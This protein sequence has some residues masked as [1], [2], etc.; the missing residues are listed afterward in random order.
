M[1][2]Q[3]RLSRAG[4]VFWAVLAVTAAAF[5]VLDGAV[6]LRIVKLN[7]KLIVLGDLGRQAERVPYAEEQL[8]LA[9]STLGDANR[10]TRIA[11]DMLA[12]V[13]EERGRLDDAL[14]LRQQEIDVIS[15]SLGP[16]H[17]TIALT[18]PQIA[19]LLYGLGRRSEAEAH[20]K[21]ALE[22]TEQ[23]EGPQ[24]ERY[25]SALE[26]VGL[27]LM[28]NGRE[29]DG[30]RL[31]ERG[32]QIQ[33]AFGK[34]DA[35]EPTDSVNRGFR[36]LSA[37]RLDDA[38]HELR[39]AIAAQ[40]R[41]YGPDHPDLVPALNGLVLV[42]GQQEKYEQ[43]E[44]IAVR[45]LAIAERAYGKDHLS[46]ASALASLA[47]VKE[48]LGAHLIGRADTAA[49]IEQLRVEVLTIHQRQLAIAE[50]QLPRNHPG[51]GEA[52]VGLGGSL[53]NAGR[54]AEAYAMLERGIEIGA[55]A[56]Q[57]PDVDFE[58]GAKDFDPLAAAYWRLMDI[59]AGMVAGRPETADETFRL[60]QSALR[61]ST[62][63]ALAQMS[64]RA[65]AG[66]PELAELVRR[67]Q[68]L[69]TEQK[70]HNS[71]IYA[72]VSLAADARDRSNETALQKALAE[73]TD[74]IAD[75]DQRL[76]TGFPRFSDLSM[77]RTIGV[78]EMQA[79]LRD[80]EVL[81]QYYVPPLPYY[82]WAKGTVWAIS[83]RAVRLV[84][85]PVTA[86]EIDD[87][88][89]AL[90]CGLDEA[91]WLTDAGRT[92][93]ANLLGLQPEDIAEAAKPPLRFSAER[94][95]ALYAALFSG[96]EDMTRGQQL[97][98]VP[99][100]PLSALPLQVL[101]TSQP[102]PGAALRDMPWLGT[103]QPITILPSAG[104]LGALRTREP[105]LMRA[106]KPYIG[107]GNPLLRGGEGD[108]AQAELARERSTCQRPGEVRIAQAT[109]AHAP[110]RPV[111]RNGLAS[112][113][114]LD[115]LGPLPETADE[116]CD[117]AAG[118][119]AEDGS[120]LLGKAASERALKKLN[121]DGVLARYRILHFATHGALSGEI[122]GSAEP[123]LVLTPPQAASRD[124]DG[125]LT[126]SEITE[127]DIAADW[128]ILSACNTAGGANQDLTSLSGL[129]RAFFYAGARALL[130]SHW[131]VNSQASVLLATRAFGALA[132]DPS[133]GRAEAMRA[134]MA[135]LATSDQPYQNHPSYW[136][137]FVLV[138]EGG[139]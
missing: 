83:R 17:R 100:G 4:V 122:E 37:G 69:V 74:R 94:A 88:V 55:A 57:T 87:Q 137:P 102:S 22:L 138:G 96:I 56:A 26:H 72:A 120:V 89:A 136:A 92:R 76:A 51:V 35:Q 60:A 80:D 118:L 107:F 131:A 81:I 16:R 2:Y 43:A 91:A 135:S 7:L 97:L 116:L 5:V 52:L 106:D 6:Y 114:D 95:H 47:R 71:A 18:H 46:L 41:R 112:L 129:A 58:R 20:L 42:L 101:L 25:G 99:S 61:T 63:T 14:A 10:M 132:R 127:L 67:R 134:A 108:E 21:T 49:R 8:R 90:R 126:A 104:S 30:K 19:R 77:P 48:F 119:G 110:A 64:V 68:D 3:V 128:V 130:V 11:I 139:N 78:G 98:V 70:R 45:V 23:T 32:R 12:T 84:A 34:R 39:Q 125:Y 59:G 82:G 79:L 15:R 13:Y 29:A 38:I 54:P 31:A 62:G 9:R 103:R 133:I 1:G 117:V 28:I 85:L 73:A 115:R 109:V 113:A 111:N 40:E 121:A 44:V 105:R 27:T 66:T 123:G 36:A 124:D 86:K 93:C 75:I 50:A 53:A 24:S 65:S 33:Q